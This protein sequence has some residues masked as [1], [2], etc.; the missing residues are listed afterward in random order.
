MVGGCRD[1]CVESVP[2][3]AGLYFCAS[4]CSYIL[5]SSFGPLTAAAHDRG[6]VTPCFITPLCALARFLLAHPHTF[7]MLAHSRTRS[8]QFATHRPKT[9]PSTR[10]DHHHHRCCCRCCCHCRHHHHRHHH[11]HHRHRRQHRYHRYHQHCHYY[12]RQHKQHRPSHLPPEVLLWQ[13]PF[14]TDSSTPSTEHTEQEFPP[15]AC[16][17]QGST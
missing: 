3:A 14:E 7:F 9:L 11:R 16:T 15:S 6:D 13:Q 2:I 12:Y 1:R 17:T 8:L 4:V 10:A 5:G